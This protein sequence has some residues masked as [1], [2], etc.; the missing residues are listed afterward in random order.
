MSGGVLTAGSRL[1]QDM[2]A[3]LNRASIAAG[4]PADQPLEWTEQELAALGA[5]C[6][7]ADRAEVLADSFGTELGG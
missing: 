1:R 2:D 7:A 5:A 4:Q 6:A 3:A